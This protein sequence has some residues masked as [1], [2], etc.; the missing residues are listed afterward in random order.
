MLQCLENHV[1]ALENP[2]SDKLTFKFKSNY[3]ME[4]TDLK[5]NSNLQFIK[6]SLRQLIVSTQPCILFPFKF[7]YKYY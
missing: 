5:E 3:T 6:T 1:K 2:T 4:K 7:I